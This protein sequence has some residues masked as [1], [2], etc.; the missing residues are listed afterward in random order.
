MSTQ[1]K[2]QVGTI[3]ITPSWEA[4][5]PI[6]LALLEDG[7]EHGKETAKDGLMRMAKLADAYVA[8]KKEK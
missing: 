7:S 1:S 3:D 8:L 5:V 2:I 4:V 6:F